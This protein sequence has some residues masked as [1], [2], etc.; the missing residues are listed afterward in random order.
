MAALIV[1]ETTQYPSA[2]PR[3][4]FL[5]ACVG[6][7]PCMA[8]RLISTQRADIE[9]QCEQSHDAPE[10]KHNPRYCAFDPEIA[11]HARGYGHGEKGKP[12]YPWVYKRAQAF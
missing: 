12:I 10:L 5:A 3:F 6:S 7:L 1:F 9:R 2:E 8:E 11:R 4:A